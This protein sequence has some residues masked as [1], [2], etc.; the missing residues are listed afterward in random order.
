[1]GVAAQVD[2]NVEKF[3]ALG[4]D[5]PSRLLNDDQAG[6]MSDFIRSLKAFDQNLAKAKILVAKLG[7]GVERTIQ[8]CE[9]IVSD[10]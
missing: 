3:E 2:A 1:M 9:E 4:L 5:L 10:A 7:P 8:R 6:A